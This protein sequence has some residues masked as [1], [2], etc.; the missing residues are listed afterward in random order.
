M[1]YYGFFYFQGESSACGCVDCSASCPAGSF[2]DVVEDED[3]LIGEL[4]GVF[5]IMLI[6]FAVGSVLF[7]GV[8][9]FFLLARNRQGKSF[10]TN[11]QLLQNKNCSRWVSGNAFFLFSAGFGFDTLQGHNFVFR[12]SSYG[13]Q[14]QTTVD[15]PCCR[16]EYR[17]LSQK[18]CSNFQQHW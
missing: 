1:I 12:S 4:D 15:S 13:R 14:Y 16:V 17:S 11:D 3:F 8:A 5:V 7:V 2:D 10:N 18:T 6:I 9:I